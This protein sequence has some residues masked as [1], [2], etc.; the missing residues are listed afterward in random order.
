MSDK[1]VTQ[2]AAGNYHSLALDADG[3]LYAAGRNYFGQLGL[4]DADD[5][6][7]FAEIASLNGKKIVAIAAGDSHSL[8]LDADGKVYGTGDNDFGQLGLGE[9]R[10]RNVW[11]LAPPFSE[12]KIAWIAAGVRHSLALDE[13]GKVYAAGNNYEGQLGLSVADDRRVFTLVPLPNR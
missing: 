3:R 7:K 12:K 6:W 13:S 2:I 1:N 10:D 5:R 9:M 8:A 4:G 11:T